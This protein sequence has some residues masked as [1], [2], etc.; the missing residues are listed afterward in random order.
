MSEQKKVFVADD[1]PTALFSL[2]ELLSKSGFLVESTD[3]P[4]EVVARVNNFKPHLILLDLVMPGLDGFTVCETLQGDKKTRGIPIIAISGLAGYADMERAYNLGVV[5]YFTKPYD[6]QKLL[7]EINSAIAYKEALQE[8]RNFISAVLDTAGALIVVLDRQG[9]IVRW[10]AACELITGYAF[11]EIENKCPWDIFLKPQEKEEARAAFENSYSGQFPRKSENC[12]I[13]KN[14]ALRTIAW[15]DTALTDSDGTIKNIVST[16]IDITERTLAE[17]RLQDA[18]DELRRA[19][20]QLVQ[21]AKMA[22]IGRIANWVAHE[23]KNPLAIIIQGTDYLKSQVASEPALREPAQRITDAALRADR[24]VKDLLNFSRQST[25]SQEEKEIPP[26]IEESL[27]LVEH[28]MSLRNVQILREFPSYTP[29]VK[30]DVNQMKQVFINI[31]IN[32]VEAM[33]GGGKISIVVGETKE[34]T[35]R[36][37]LEIVFSDTG[38]GILEENIPKVFETFFS[39]KKKEGSAGLGLPITKEIVE[40]HGGRIMIESKTGKGTSVRIKLPVAEPL[41]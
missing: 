32:A 12:W 17:E 41:T 4:G 26:V 5:A 13:T 39:T 23:I 29:K 25:S 38:E 33:P 1:D 19:Q 30:M 11:Q 35:G 7:K 16:G 20:I 31:L 3:S 8:E 2:K 40:K 9:R 18:Y 6:F 15:S 10:N 21:S 14:G 34:E 28:Q 24:I 36:R 37:N 27:S 22:A